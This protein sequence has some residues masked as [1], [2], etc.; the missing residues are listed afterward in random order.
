MNIAQL[1][2]WFRLVKAQGTNF[3]F[4]MQHLFVIRFL[5]QCMRTTGVP[6]TLLLVLSAPTRSIGQHVGIELL[7]NKNDYP[8]SGYNDIWGYVD[9]AGIEYAVLGV[10]TG[11]AIYGLADPQ[12]PI[13][14]AYIPG[15]KSIWRDMK[16][17]AGFVYAL[18]D[19]GADGI[20]A[21][22]MR[23]AAD[24]I[25][26]VFHK[27]VI[28]LSSL[29]RCHNLYIDEK[30]VMY[31]SGCNIN[32]GG[33]LLFD[34]A[35]TPGQPKFLGI[36]RNRYSHDNFVRGDTLWSADVY[37]G[38]FSVQDVTDKRAPKLIATHGTSNRFTHNCWLSDDGKTLFTT[39]ELALGT[40]DAYDVSVLGDV[41]FLDRFMPASAP[42]NRAIPH[43]VHYYKGF[44]ATSWYTEGVVLTDA[45]RPENL[46]EIGRY[47]TYAGA[48]R[49]FYGCWGAYPFLPS[50]ILLASDI[51]TGLYV[52]QP[53][54]QR[55]CYLEG[56]VR[57][58]ET[59]L[60]V[61]EAVLQ[62][63]SGDI[64]EKTGLDGVFRGGKRTPGR[65]TV[66]IHATGYASDTAI[67]ELK[68]GI[69][70]PLNVVLKK[71]VLTTSTD[72]RTA[73]LQGIQVYPNPT[74]GECSFQWHYAGSSAVRA[75][76]LWNVH[77]VLQKVIPLTANAGTLQTTLPPGGYQVVLKSTE[78]QI[79]AR[80][81]LFVH[82]F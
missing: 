19:Q 22:D 46:V 1:Q 43:N 49:G 58:A 69:V 64:Q 73:N 9:S 24:T 45:H 40:V 2:Y 38:Q 23:K 59:G 6:L 26:W 16:S 65:D 31:L 68:S 72:Q 81:T 63:R 17:F 76:E 47:D 13:L 56:S 18:A 5:Y 77:G 70:T 14:R 29:N 60:P 42:A 82:G 32:S 74:S 35:T 10:Q 61:K 33:V 55:A 28:D 15:A 37:D 39:D 25:T 41:R 21:I 11:V 20:L 57:D 51:Q 66:F 80:T 44:L 36:A 78:A 34:V 52:L 3:V 75:I 79:L 54:Y 7:A 30:G 53:T 71:A 62:T 4:Q 48:G 8:A 12:K 27:P 67:V 50:G